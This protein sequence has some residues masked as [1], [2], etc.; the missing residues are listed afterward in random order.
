MKYAEIYLIK[1]IKSGWPVLFVSMGCVCT[2]LEHAHPLL[3]VYT[4]THSSA[5]AAFM[6]SIKAAHLVESS[7]SAVIK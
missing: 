4:I 1:Y 6:D 5:N 3:G 7:T 2:L